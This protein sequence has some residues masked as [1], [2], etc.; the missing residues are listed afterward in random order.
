MMST[1]SVVWLVLI[2]ETGGYSIDAVARSIDRRGFVIA[3]AA[4]APARAAALSEADLID[5][6]KSARTGLVALPKMVGDQQWDP[7]R[8]ELRRPA[9]AALWNVKESANSIRQL[10]ALRGDPELIDAADDVSRQLFDVDQIVYSNMFSMEGK[11]AGA[12]LRQDG[13]AVGRAGEGGGKYRVKE[14]QDLVRAAVRSIDGI[15]AGG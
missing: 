2:A 14:P 4:A 12:G 15:L 5:E 3:A 7:V 10:A 8:S 6:I 11:M 1:R 13:G 9:V